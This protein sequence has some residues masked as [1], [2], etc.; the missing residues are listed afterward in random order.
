M[1]FSRFARFIFN[2]CVYECS[3]SL[4]DLHD[5]YKINWLFED[6]LQSSIN[7]LSQPSSPA[8]GA[9]TPAV[10]SCMPVVCACTPAVG[11]CTPAVGACTPVVGACTPAVRACTPAGGLVRGY[12]VYHREVWNQRVR[13]LQGTLQWAPVKYACYQYKD[14][15][16]LQVS[17]IS[18]IYVIQFHR[19]AFLAL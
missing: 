7:I 16:A 3:V 13:A 9:C 15:C 19:I 4:Q 18:F 14:V 10:R 17:I 2:G 12:L 5:H 1:T 8:D 6:R 11:A